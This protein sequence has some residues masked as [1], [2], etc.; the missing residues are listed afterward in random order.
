MVKWSILRGEGRLTA[1]LA[2][3]FFLLV[4]ALYLMKPARNAL[5]IGEFGTDYLP[6][7]YVATALAT[8]WVVVAYVRSTRMARLQVI[9]SA[10]LATTLI[11][12]AVFWYWLS[13]SAWGGAMPFYVWVKLYAVLLPSQFWLFAEEV[14]DPR[15][16]RR[17]FAPIGAGGILGGIVG[18]GVA[19]VLADRGLEARLLL[20]I[21][22][23]A[24]AAALLLF[25]LVLA[26]AP[27]RQ[28]RG[29]ASRDDSQ[30][31]T[32]Y[33]P[34]GDRRS[35]AGSEDAD[36]TPHGRKLIFTITAILVIA[37]MA[38]TIVDWQFNRA[39]EAEFLSEQSLTRFFAAFNLILNIVTLVVQMLATSFLLR[40]FGIGVAMGLLPAAIA[41]GA[42]GILLF[43][44]NPIWS[45]GLARGADDALRFSVD[46]SGR[47][48][49]FLPF[50]SE[51]RR[52]LKPRIDL[53]ASRA[54][55]GV[56]GLVIIA[57]LFLFEDPLRYLSIVS[58]LLVA[59][60]AALVYDARRQ[61][62]QTL[63]H[64]LRVRDL[65][66]AG[67]ARS[68]LDADAR[69]AIREGLAS[70]DDATVH[71]ALSLAAHTEPGAFVEE[72]RTVL[73]TSST[74]SVKGQVLHL[75][76]EAHDSSA[77]AEALAN[78]DQD[79]HALTAEALAYAC[80]TGR[81]EARER[82]RIYLSGKN[83]TRAVSAAV[84][85]LDQPDQQ[86][87]GIDILREA[88]ITPT[89]RAVELRVAIADVIR[90]RP[91]IDELRPILAIL[92][93]DEA[94]QVVRAALAA[95]GHFS[96]PDLISP[97]CEAGMRRVLQGPALQAL[98]LM[99]AAAVGA[100]TGLL[101][102]PQNRGALRR[103]TARALGRVGGPDAAAGLIAGLVAEDRTVR[104]ATLKA[105]N[106]MLRRGEKL[107]IGRQREAAAIAIEWRDYLSL[108]RL[109]GAL[110]EPG[111]ET[112][113]A[114]VATVVNERLRESEEQLFRALALHHPIQSVFFAYRGLITGDRVARAHA[115]DLV[116]SIVETPQRRALVRL[117]ETNDRLARSHIAAQESGRDVPSAAEAL[118]ELL[119]PGDPW[120]AACAIQAL[121]ARPDDLPR[122]LRQ[123]LSAH[124]YAPLT[125][126]LDQEV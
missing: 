19:T 49:L 103:F 1:G 53:I 68:R 123:E 39:A 59:A 42:F 110:G 87:R 77:L 76:T 5:F 22:A 86:S 70:A 88:A 11:C 37:T 21:A 84:C 57:A 25:H 126:L 55:N 14:L 95:A 116:D 35:N 111:T 29:A 54:A 30:T 125:E 23:V 15:Q 62:A 69:D 26:K 41:S 18:S 107:E 89:P 48:L 105:L 3:Y 64:L 60:W 61:Y 101:A 27:A 33:E 75:L 20:I 31:L 50:S 98:Q 106:Y 121:E 119:D 46:Q 7:V 97:I 79:D 17:L 45:T 71:T 13:D 108:Q 72:L 12:L 112:P 40:H 99:G 73:R 83:A 65:D 93:R 44:G 34:T 6:Y 120:L 4:A 82:V 80:A 118:Q 8:W 124:G 100:L 96:H 16:A 74:P 9:L 91:R 117:L 51:D 52:R 113:T 114:F 66:I 115:I 24:V 58:L 85:L 38:H 28:V 63:Q 78:V 81:P 2:G 36:A 90:Q 43:P 47:E 102:N 92:L 56:A 67:L 10:T 104:K 109:A 94:P 32:G 122:G